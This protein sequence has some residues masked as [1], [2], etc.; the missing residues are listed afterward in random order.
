MRRKNSVLVKVCKS[1]ELK[2]GQGKSVRVGDRSIAIFNVN[3]EFFAVDDSCTHMG[4]PL[5]KGML[6]GKSITCE[7]HGACFDLQTGA[8]LEGPTRGDL[9]SYKVIVN[10]DDLEIDV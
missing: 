2:P 8:A 5:A 1:D 6:A 7:W 9:Q 10:D 3:G 4:A